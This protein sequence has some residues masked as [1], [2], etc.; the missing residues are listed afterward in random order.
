MERPLSGRLYRASLVVL[1]IPVLAAA[2]TVSRPAPLPPVTAALE[3]TFDHVNAYRLAQNLVT[4]YPDRSPG[5]PASGGAA[6]WVADELTEAGTEDADRPLLRPRS[7]VAV[8]SICGTSAPSCRDARATRSSSSPTATRHEVTPERTTTPPARPRSSSSLGRTRARARPSAESARRT[9]CRSSRPMPAPTGSSA[10]GGSPEA[11]HSPSTW[12]RS[13]CSTPSGRETRRGSRSQADGPRSPAPGLVATA[14]ARLAEETGSAPEVPSALAQLIDLAFPFSLTEQY[15]FLAEHIPALTVTTE[16]SRAGE[17]PRPRRLDP[18]VLGQV[19]RA[20]ESLLASLDASLEPARGTSAYLYVGGR[21]VQRLG[22]R[23]PLRRV[24]RAVRRL[25][26]GPRRPAAAVGSTAA[27]G[28]AQ[29]SP[30]AR[31]LALRG[32]RLH[33]LRR[34]RSV[35]RR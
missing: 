4:L 22:R 2:F 1:A 25:P 12:W 18:V 29:L 34:H 7:P 28:A 14:E 5:S 23:P 15:P 33:A 11:P 21:V 30:Q 10:P 27:A 19:G 16:G 9:P 17:D 24:A 13:S 32:R 35:A 3:P 26:P 8:A 6:R 20:A 31:L